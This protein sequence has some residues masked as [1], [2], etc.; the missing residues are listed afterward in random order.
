MTRTTKRLADIHVENNNRSVAR[1]VSILHTAISQD[2]SQLA[3][4]M[5]L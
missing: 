4:V 5:R 2:R 3:L 1:I